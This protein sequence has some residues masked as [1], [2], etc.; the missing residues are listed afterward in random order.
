MRS[1]TVALPLPSSG[2][3]PVAVGTLPPAIGGLPLPVRVPHVLLVPSV[4]GG[5]SAGIVGRVEGKGVEGSRAD[6]EAQEGEEHNGRDE[7]DHG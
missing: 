7:S 6:E 3:L 5:A 2:S 4:T 1:R